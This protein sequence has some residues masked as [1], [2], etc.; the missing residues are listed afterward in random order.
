MTVQ[1]DQ[2]GGTCNIQVPAPGFALV[3]LTPGALSEVEPSTTETFATTAVTKTANTATVDPSVLATS[4]G[5]SGGDRAH[6]DSTSK[7]SN[8]AAAGRVVP[9]AC[10]LAAVLVGALVLRLA[11]RA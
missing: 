3:F 6:L 10:T 5:H 9:G 1:C 8:A 2:A 7:G 4:N 11:A